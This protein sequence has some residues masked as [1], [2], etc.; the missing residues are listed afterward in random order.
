MIEE[1]KKSLEKLAGE[2]KWVVWNFPSAGWQVGTQRQ[3]EHGT[4]GGIGTTYGEHSS[5]GDVFYASWWQ[6]PSQY[7]NDEIEEADARFIANA[8]EYVR[9]LLKRIEELESK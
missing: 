6:F 2:G 4:L 9:Y 5:Y 7:M 1:I 3:C 8:P